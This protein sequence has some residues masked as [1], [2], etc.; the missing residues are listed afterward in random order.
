M[1]STKLFLLYAITIVVII[2]AVVW[3]SYMH[4]WML[5]RPDGGADVIRVDLFVL[6]PLVITLVA[7]SLYSLIRKPKD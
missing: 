7:L 3:S 6:Y 4:D 2:F 5:A 1:K